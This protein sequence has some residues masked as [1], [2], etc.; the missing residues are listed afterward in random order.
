VNPPA[1]DVAEQQT[2]DTRG[3]T[4]VTARA[5][6]RVATAVAA[7]ELG[8]APR[9]V[10]VAVSD[11]RGLLEL[12]IDSPLRVPSLSR[13]RDDPET[14]TLGGGTVLDRAARAQ[15]GIRSRVAELTGSRVSRVTVRLTGVSITPER[16]V[17]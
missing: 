1:A 13:V 7:D 14:V 4:R 5:I 10:S 11:D 9:S 3:R 17:K 6:D 12:V 2:T 8:V 16:R 15:N